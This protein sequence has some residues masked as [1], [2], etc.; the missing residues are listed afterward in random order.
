MKVIY[1][2][3]PE[4][5]VPILDRII[6]D[7]HEVVA[8]VCQPDKVNARGNK[9][10]LGAVKAYA[11]EKGIKVLQYNKIRLEGVEELKAL[12]ADV[13]V[14]AAYGQLLSQEILDICP[15]GV[16]NVHGSLLPKYRGASPIMQVII[17]GEKTTGITIMKTCIGMDDG[18]MYL[19][20][21]LEIGEHETAGELSIRMSNLGAE[22]L[23]KVLKQIEN[24][25]AVLTEQ[26]HAN[27]TTC[28]K[29]KKEHTKI[30]FSL[31]AKKVMNFIHGLSPEP[32]AYFVYNDM[33]IKV[34]NASVCDYDGEA[35]AGEVV[36]ATPK[37]GLIVKCGE[38]YIALETIQAPG[39]K[40]MRAKD[41]L[42]GKKIEVG[43]II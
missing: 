9:I 30:D 42:N 32:S 7:G 28:K 37:K 25:S 39:G 27:A 10:V 34:F 4:F 14:T 40:K 17:D 29:Y 22:C 6:S 16:V 38:G 33:E 21:S 1:L 3:S 41:Y 20:E 18:P 15:F 2:G 12:K 5:G 11:L 26:D 35:S 13:M 19:M 36:V 24:G 23:S 43:T 31:S 8:V